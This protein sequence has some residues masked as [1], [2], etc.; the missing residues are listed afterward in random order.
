[1]DA[2]MTV[3]IIHKGSLGVTVRWESFGA[4]WILEAPVVLMHMR[5]K[6]DTRSLYIYSYILKCNNFCCAEAM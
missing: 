5:S 4:G 2:P 6:P 3:V 1:M